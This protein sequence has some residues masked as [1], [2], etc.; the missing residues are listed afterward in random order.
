MSPKPIIKWS[1]LN[2][3]GTLAYIALV[4]LFMSNAETWFGKVPEYF[5]GITMLTLFVF[6][7]AI[8]SSLV[9]GRPILW[10]LDGAKGEALRLFAFTLSWI[11]LILCVLM[12][13]LIIIQQ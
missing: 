6:S 1:L 4:V 10:Y 5:A 13:V 7:A 2:A 12:L 8:V 11:L 3:F 9:L